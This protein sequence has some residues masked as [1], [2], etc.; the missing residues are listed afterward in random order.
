MLAPENERMTRADH[1]R[2]MNTDQLAELFTATAVGRH[3]A[4]G[5]DETDPTH[6]A[7]MATLLEGAE[8]LWHACGEGFDAAGLT[9][10]AAT[11]KAA[12]ALLGQCGKPQGSH[13]GEHGYTFR[14]AAPVLADLAAISPA[15]LAATVPHAVNGQRFA[16]VLGARSAEDRHILLCLLAERAGML[17]P[18]ARFASDW[19][20]DLVDTT[21]GILGR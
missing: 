14:T 10:L 15:A 5:V 20:D 6:A 12:K 9:D 1:D 13:K 3:F 18:M 8:G 17:R 2:R 11:A 21:T 7:G 16:M 19:I 4:I